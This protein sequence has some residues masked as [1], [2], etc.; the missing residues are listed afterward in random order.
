MLLPLFKKPG[1][2]GGG[3][4]GGRGGE[5]KALSAGLRVTPALAYFFL[6]GMGFMFIEITLIQKFI[7]FLEHPEFAFSA[8]VS[9]LLVS[10]G[11]GSFLS[12]RFGPERTIKIAIP[13]LVVLLIPFTLLLSPVLN[14]SLGLA[15]ALRV[16]LTAVRC[17]GPGP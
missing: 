11:A 8:V 3:G 7:L 14:A 15:P 13:V 6:L 4:G 16:L 9:V 5:G 2:N 10:S 1:G 17:R 12:Q